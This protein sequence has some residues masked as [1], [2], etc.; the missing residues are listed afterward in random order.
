M[1]TLEDQKHSIH[2]DVEQMHKH[3]ITQYDSFGVC[4]EKYPNHD[5]MCADKRKRLELCAQHYVEQVKKIFVRCAPEIQKYTECVNQAESSD[6]SCNSLY[7][8]VTQCS[9]KG[10]N[11]P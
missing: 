11:Q 4:M 8:A 10:I 3:C 6:A 9:A 1:S 7:D 5:Y 2:V